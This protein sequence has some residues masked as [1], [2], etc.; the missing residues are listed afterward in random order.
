MTPFLRPALISL[1]LSLASGLAAAQQLGH[2][3]GLTD[4]GD[5]VNITVGLDDFSQVAVRDIGMFWMATCTKSGPGR[6]VGWG[7]GTSQPIVD[8]KAAIEVRGNSLYM[9][10]TLKFNAA[11]DTVTGTVTGRTP[12]FTDVSTSTKS[13]QMCDSGKRTFSA[14]LVPAARGQAPLARGEI[15]ALTR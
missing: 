12:E 1:A 9:A 10:W 8:R 14:T 7:V 11:G 2:F 6:G 4:N 5:E 13:V 3:Q 15:R